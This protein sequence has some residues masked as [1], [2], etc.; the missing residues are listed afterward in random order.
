MKRTSEE[1]MINRRFGKLVV[2][3]KG[4]NY[5]D[6]RGYPRDMWVC[7]CDCNNTKT[8]LGLNLRSGNSKSCGCATKENAIKINTKHGMN[9]TRLHEIWV[10]MR[11]RCNNKKC[12]C[13]KSYGGRGITVCNEWKDFESF[14]NW[15]IVNGYSDNLS[16]D[17]IDVNGNYCPE[18]CRWAT[19]KVQ[20]NNTRR[21]RLIT[22][23]GET[24]TAA[25]WSE[26]T[27][28][29]SSVIRERIDRYGWP[30]EKALTERSLRS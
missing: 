27:G 10:G 29:K 8:I 4:D 11:K 26:L 3:E 9:R 18:N 25:E 6:K 16:L 17:R 5:I 30:V 24:H 28:I 12:K 2:V 20:M 15:A 19:M 14:Y 1:Y 13:Y 21:N 22:Y 23:N 7:K